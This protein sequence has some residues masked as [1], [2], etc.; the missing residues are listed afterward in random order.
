MHG[1]RPDPGHTPTPVNRTFLRTIGAGVVV[2]VACL[3]AASPAGAAT[4]AEQVASASLSAFDAIVLGIVEENGDERLVARAGREPLQRDARALREVHVSLR[5]LV[6][7]IE[8]MDHRTI[9]H[10]VS[11]LRWRPL[12]FQSRWIASF[13]KE[14]GAAAFG[15]VRSIGRS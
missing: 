14:A 11:T 13:V 3:A 4:A 9:A 8:R 7:T 10:D 6:R 15:L 1:S 5:R 2:A 12:S